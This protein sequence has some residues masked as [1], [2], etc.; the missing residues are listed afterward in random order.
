MSTGWV[1]SVP[2]WT[3]RC[4]TASMGEFAEMAVRSADSSMR[5]TGASTVSDAS[6]PSA[7]SSTDSLRLLDP[8]LTTRILT[9]EPIQ[10]SGSASLRASMSSC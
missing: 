7:S 10:V 5:P 4:P 8:A 6:K 2:P 9:S 3:M 1:N